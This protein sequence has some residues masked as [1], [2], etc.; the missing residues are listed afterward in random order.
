MQ[1]VFICW[2][3]WLLMLTLVGLILSPSHSSAQTEFRAADTSSPRAT[4]KSFIEACNE[5]HELIQTHEI[6]DRTHSEH[7]PIALRVLD[8]VNASDLPAFAQEERAAEVAVC[9][10]EII[11]RHELPPWD[12]IPDEAAIEA[13]GGI[14]RFSRW[15]IPGTRLTIS[16]VEDGPQKHEYLFSPGTVDRAVRYLR[17]VESRPYR[18]DEPKTSPGFYKWYMSAPGHPAVA[19]IVRRLPER[20]RFGR[21]FGLANWKWLGLPALLC[22]A[23]ALMAFLYRL[24]YAL[25]RRIGSDR[26]L[27][28]CL[29]LILPFLAM[30]VPFLFEYTASNYLTIRGNPLY[31][32]SFFSNAVATLAVIVFVFVLC[33][34]IAETVIASPRVNPQGLNAQ[35]IRIALKLLSFVLAVAVFMIGGQYIGIHVGTLLASAGIGGIA[36]ALGAQDTLKTLFG[37]VMMMADKP[38]RVGDR[39]VFKGYDGMVEDI[40]L[41]STRIRLLTSHQVTVP[42]DELAR[43]ATLRTSADVNAFAEW[44]TFI[45]RLILRTRKPSLPWRSCGSSWRI[46]KACRRTTRRASSLSIFFPRHSRFARSTG[47][48]RRTTGTIW[49]S[50]RGSTFPSFVHL[51]STAFS[52]RCH[53]E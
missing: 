47:T 44:W 8:C 30:L 14:E 5:F 52:F 42:N 3:R 29:I 31:I 7:N 13:A 53:I 22:L 27:P 48:T 28:H 39:I 21:S 26:I 38:F 43:R 17:D 20:M 32:V 11:D 51:R 50:A 1:S 40:G 35:L 25:S 46:T 49:H 23:V 45:F 19:A 41:R 2:L 18:T 10:K 24:Y 16:R 33:S 4:L 9:I 36:L 15:R 34:T 12:E 37:T 6:L